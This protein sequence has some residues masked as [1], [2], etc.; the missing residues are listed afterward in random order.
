MR[1][2]QI[3]KSSGSFAGSLHPTVMPVASARMVTIKKK[4][5]GANT[6]VFVPDD[7][8]KYSILVKILDVTRDYKQPDGTRLPLFPEVVMSGLVQ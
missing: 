7:D 8:I 1:A 6:V 5:T 3:F 4:F 2:S